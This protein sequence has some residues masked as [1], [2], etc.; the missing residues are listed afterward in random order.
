MQF[1]FYFKFL[2]QSEELQT[3]L[4]SGFVFCLFVVFLFYCF[5]CF[6]VFCV[7]FFVVFVVVD[8]LY[9]LMGCLYVKLL[10]CQTFGVLGYLIILYC[11]KF[12]LCKP[13]V[14]SKLKLIS[15]LEIIFV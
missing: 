9:V 15:K 13:I 10:F 5:D 4:S 6:L 8:G 7:C 1:L 2:S 12:R 14:L 11:W 3:Y